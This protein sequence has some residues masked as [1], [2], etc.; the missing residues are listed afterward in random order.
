MLS[1]GR[2]HAAATPAR[3][4][5]VMAGCCTILR[6]ALLLL[7]AG[8]GHTQS[9]TPRKTNLHSPADTR[10]AH[11]LAA[12]PNP[13]EILPTPAQPVARSPQPVSE[14]K[15]LP[16]TKVRGSEK[17]VTI[18]SKSP[19]KVVST[20]SRGPE[21]AVAPGVPAASGPSERPPTA[22]RPPES[23]TPA[24]QASNIASAPPI[25]ELIFKGPPHPEPKPRSVTKALGWLGIGLGGVALAILARLLAS[26]RAKPKEIP[27]AG[28]EELPIAR[29]LLFKE[30]LTET[31]EPAAMGR[32]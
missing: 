24:T 12:T 13:P 14:T 11:N 8:C 1:E 27:I 16:A 22:A 2:N 17:L 15:P 29:E 5:A 10:T 23:K 18:S 4:S 7:L 28:R 30:P 3:A 9:D 26:S 6:S 19:D 25:A 21:K 31:N 20:N 32:R